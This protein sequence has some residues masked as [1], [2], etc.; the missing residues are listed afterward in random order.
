VRRLLAPL[1]GIALVASLLAGCAEEGAVESGAILSVYV[2]APL[3]GSE[4]DAGRQLCE[5]ARAEAQEQGRIGDFGVRVIC[6]D[7]SGPE[8]EWTLARV[9]DNARRATEDSTA[10][11]YI[12]EPVQAARRQSRPIVEA[13]GI[14]AIGGLGGREAMAKVLAAIRDDDQGDPRDAVLDALG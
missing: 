12:G 11:A 4:A 5:D 10:V 2:S 3:R 14:A 1:I 6:L 13:A 9:G 8:G 7:A